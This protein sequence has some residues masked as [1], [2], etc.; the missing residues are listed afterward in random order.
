M[1]TQED[2]DYVWNLINNVSETTSYLSDTVYSI[3]LEER[4]KF[5]NKEY[6]AAELSEIL[7]KRLSIAV[8]E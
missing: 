7:Q 4:E 1:P 3:Y 8:A 5:F 6:T 2:I